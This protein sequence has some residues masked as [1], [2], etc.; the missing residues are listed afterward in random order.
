MMVF[1]DRMLRLMSDGLR[2][3]YVAFDALFEH[4]HLSLRIFPGMHTLPLMFCYL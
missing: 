1:I 3:V 4:L 2:S